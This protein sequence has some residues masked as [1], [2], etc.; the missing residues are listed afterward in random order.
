MTQMDSN[1]S[2]LQGGALCD[3]PQCDGSD[4]TIG[5]IRY[6]CVICYD[7]DFCASC[8]TL[9][10]ANGSHPH[11][12]L[13]Y[14]ED[15]EAKNTWFFRRVKRPGNASTDS[16][17]SETKGEP[18]EEMPSGTR[19]DRS[20]YAMFEEFWRDCDA[21]D[22]ALV[23]EACSSMKEWLKLFCFPST[24]VFDDLRWQNVMSELSN[25]SLIQGCSSTTFGK[26]SLSFH[27]VVQ[28]WVRARCINNQILY[29]IS[30]YVILSIPLYRFRKDSSALRGADITRMTTEDIP[31]NNE[32]VLAATS[33]LIEEYGD[34]I[35]FSVHQSDPTKTTHCGLQELGSRIWPGLGFA[36]QMQLYGNTEIPL[37]LYRRFIHHLT[38]END[39]DTKDV[40][41]IF[42]ATII[43]LG[44]RQ[45]SSEILLD[46]MKQLVTRSREQPGNYFNHALMLMTMWRVAKEHGDDELHQQSCMDFRE[47]LMKLTD[48]FRNP[49]EETLLQPALECSFLLG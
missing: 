4:I 23:Y 24:A 21:K 35:S 15:A 8:E 49:L 7:V 41:N 43:R 11:S 46:D 16:D 25:L 40:R 37:K 32:A 34:H 18:Q 27:R 31:S 33:S 29:Q 36:V 20:S 9:L 12:L 10:V 39:P 14:E 30:A 38:A 2:A 28:D 44:Y 48:E 13:E 1:H 6:N 26:S 17:D 3:G 5:N 47:M 22:Q 19:S 45:R 42:H